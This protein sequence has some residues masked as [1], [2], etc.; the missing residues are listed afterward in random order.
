MHGSNSFT[1]VFAEN[2]NMRYSAKQLEYLKKCTALFLL[3]YFHKFSSSR[4]HCQFKNHRT[5]T[6]AS[7]NSFKVRLLN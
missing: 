4:T 2:D 1:N 3:N 7:Y 5:R 6:N